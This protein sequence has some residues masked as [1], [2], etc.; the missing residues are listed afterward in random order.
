[1][2]THTCNP[3]IGGGWDDVVMWEGLRGAQPKKCPPLAAGMSFWGGVLIPFDKQS[4]PP[5]EYA[6][7]CGYA[8]PGACEDE[9]EEVCA[10]N[11]P[12][13]RACVVANSRR[14]CPPDYEAQSI[15]AS[16][17]ATDL[18]WTVCCIRDPKDP[19]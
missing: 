7:G 18:D 13:W 5:P 4:V 9:L 14:E 8:E 2:K 1:M 19:P 3:R 16:D 11:I 17:E 6:V 15:V 10:P 12:D